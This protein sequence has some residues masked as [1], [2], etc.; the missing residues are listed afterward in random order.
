MGKYIFGNEC[1]REESVGM[2]TGI[3]LYELSCDGKGLRAYFDNGDF[4]HIHSD[5]LSAYE[6]RVR[7]LLRKSA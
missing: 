1:N 3:A 7:D 4:Y 2:S 6:R 5:E